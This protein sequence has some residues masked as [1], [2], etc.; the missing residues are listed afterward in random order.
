MRRGAGERPPCALTLG[1][2]AARW[3]SWLEGGWRRRP[4]RGACRTSPRR[5]GSCW[6]GGGEWGGVGGV[7]GLYAGRVVPVKRRGSAGTGGRGAEVI[8]LGIGEPCTDAV[9]VDSH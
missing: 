3:S 2:R 1:P 4:V 5:P 8:V 7:E 9:E 6:L